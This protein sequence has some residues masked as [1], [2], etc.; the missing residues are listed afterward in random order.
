MNLNISSRGVT[1]KAEWRNENGE[2]ETN[3]YTTSVFT[4]T[5]IKSGYYTLNLTA[6]NY[7]SSFS[8]LITF[9]VYQQLKGNMQQIKK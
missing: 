9:H 8:K 2:V 3:D 6:E 1:Y 7:V 5:F 4:K